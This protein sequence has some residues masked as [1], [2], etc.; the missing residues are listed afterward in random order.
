MANRPT[1]GGD[2]ALFITRINNPNESAFQSLVAQ[3]RIILSYHVRAVI[4]RYYPSITAR[5]VS[6]RFA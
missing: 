1:A 4:V 6:G 3:V 2:N 5:E